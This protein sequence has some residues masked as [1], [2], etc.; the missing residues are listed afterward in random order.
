MLRQ[1]LF[2]I[3]NVWTD[4]DA[5]DCMRSHEGCKDTVR[6]S[7]LEVDCGR[8]IP[9]RTGDFN[10]YQY[11]AWLFNRTFYQLSYFRPSLWSRNAFWALINPVFITLMTH[12][13]RQSRALIRVHSVFQASRVGDPVL[14]VDAW[15]ESTTLKKKI[16]KKR[17]RKNVI[18]TLDRINCKHKRKNVIITLDRINC[19]HKIDIFWSLVIKVKTTTTDKQKKKKKKKREERT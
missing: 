11:C 1:P 2:G 18:I 6:Q 12:P 17:G 7:A 8:K 9:C 10:P 5:Y 19:K 13:I 15:W 3:F 4:V 14:P 16:K